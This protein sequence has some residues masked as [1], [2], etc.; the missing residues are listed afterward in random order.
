M[1]CCAK[2]IC[3]AVILYVG[4][5]LVLYSLTSPGGLG[6]GW[7]VSAI[8]NFIIVPGVL[9]A[10]RMTYNLHFCLKQTLRHL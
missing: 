1:L 6:L 10:F 8:L 3:G 5:E 9:I 7:I 4:P 2:L